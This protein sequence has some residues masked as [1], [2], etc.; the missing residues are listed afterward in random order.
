[1]TDYD[2]HTCDGTQ[3]HHCNCSHATQ[4]DIS[5]WPLVDCQVPSLR[6][7]LWAGGFEFLT[8]SKYISEIHLKK[9]KKKPTMRNFFFKTYFLFENYFYI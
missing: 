7:H 1:M 2:L 3:F 4:S 5:T 9:Q 8:N 6:C